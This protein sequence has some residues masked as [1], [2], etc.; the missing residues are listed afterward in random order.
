VS[1]VKKLSL[2]NATYNELVSTMERLGI[3]FTLVD[4]DTPVYVVRPNNLDIQRKLP[5]IILNFTDSIEDEEIVDQKTSAAKY[6]DLDGM[7]G[8]ISEEEATKLRA[9]FQRSREE[10]WD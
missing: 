7:I 9:E 5:N 1:T 10:D 6:S 4:G 8:A 3:N 2:D